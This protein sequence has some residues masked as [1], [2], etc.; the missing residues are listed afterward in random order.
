MVRPDSDNP[1]FGL[2]SKGVL[3][4]VGVHG[5]RYLLVPLA[6]RLEFTVVQFCGGLSVP[7]R[8]SGRMQKFVTKT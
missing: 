6:S 3:A 2:T 4:N 1:A 5:F 8:E 7:A